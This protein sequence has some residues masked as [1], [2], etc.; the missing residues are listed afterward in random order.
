MDDPDLQLLAR[1][2]RHGDE[3]AFAEVLRR[4]LDLVHSVALRH[5]RSPPLAEEVAQSVFTDLARSARRLAPDTILPAWL[6]SVARRTAIDAARRETRRRLRE[7]AAYELTAMNAPAADWIAIEPLLDEALHALDD[8]DRAVVLLRWFENKSLREIGVALGTSED[9]AQK[10]AGRALERLREFF[11][12]RGVTASAG[13]LAAVISANAVQAAPAGLAAAVT[14]HVYA[15]GFVTS[16]AVPLLAAFFAMNNSTKTALAT[17]LLFAVVAIPTYRHFRLVDKPA[18]PV[19]AAT[20][21]SAAAADLAAEPPPDSS[22][23]ANTI[24]PALVQAALTSLVAQQQVDALA[25]EMNTA[26][27]FVTSG[28][29]LPFESYRFSMADYPTTAEGLRALAIPPADKEKYAIWSGPYIGGNGTPLDPWG[30]PYQYTYPGTQKPL[31]Y[32]L[33]SMGPDG[34]SGT[35]DDIGNWQQ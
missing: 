17:A 29:R 11:A 7:H 34:I 18:R 28:I 26:Q 30:N 23:M 8:T 3:A 13:G 20:V 19:V 1:D 16:P 21:A 10:R 6:W 27:A 15:A 22:P 4:H 9:A 31:G 2:A 32:D 12:Q 14:G 24:D 5:V 35:A 33:W 25:A